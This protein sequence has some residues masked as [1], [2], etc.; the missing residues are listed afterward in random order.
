MWALDYGRE[1]LRSRSRWLGHMVQFF[2]YFPLFFSC[3]YK[4]GEVRRE[5]E[6]VAPCCQSHQYL[7]M[8][9]V[10]S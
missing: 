2:L 4:G 1:G 7:G 10:I 5:E 8:G 9:M 6:G 3:L